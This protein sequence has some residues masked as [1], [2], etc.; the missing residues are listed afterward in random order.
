M[1]ESRLLQLKIQGMDCAEEIAV[2]KREI[3]PLVGGE[4]RLAFDL[5]NAKVTVRLEDVRITEE[6]VLAAISRTGMNATLWTPEEKAE[7]PKGSLRFSLHAA[8]NL[9]SGIFGII[10]F[11]YMSGLKGAFKELWA[12]REWASR[13]QFR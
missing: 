6:S 12:S 2:L 9:A 13:I 8:L 1:A 11:F 5:L 4:D 10:G 7:I 3:G